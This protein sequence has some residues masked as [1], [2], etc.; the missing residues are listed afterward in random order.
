MPTDTIKWI[1]INWKVLDT[2]NDNRSI[3][4][5]T[6]A[7]ER[8][9]HSFSHRMLY[10]PCYPIPEQGSLVVTAVHGRVR[11]LQSTSVALRQGK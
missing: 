7:L 5:S 6:E 8:Y 4:G 11:D 10:P 1:E 2:I 3:I 9:V